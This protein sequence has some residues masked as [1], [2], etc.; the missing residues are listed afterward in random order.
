MKKNNTSQKSFQFLIKI[1]TWKNFNKKFCDKKKWILR[2][3]LY[4]ISIIFFRNV[5]QL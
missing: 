2:L 3:K 4:K 1:Y 5:R